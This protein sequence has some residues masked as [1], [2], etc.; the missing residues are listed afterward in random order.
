MRVAVAGV[1]V[2]YEHALIRG[3]N[4]YATGSDRH[5]AG[6][7]S[8]VWRFAPS[9]EV[10]GRTDVLRVREPHEDHF[11]DGRLRETSLMLAYKPTH[12]QTVRLQLT[13][14]RAGAG[15]D[16]ATH[17]VQ[18]QYIISFGRHAAHSF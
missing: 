6:Y 4:R 13:R 14:Q 17:A 2:A 3:L 11:D 16:T 7:L 9:W 8:V 1:R 5:Q 15:F 18:L 10:G 12:M